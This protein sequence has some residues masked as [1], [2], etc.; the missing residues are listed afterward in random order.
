MPSANGNSTIHNNSTKSPS[1]QG[2]LPWYVQLFQGENLTYVFIGLSVLAAGILLCM[3]VYFCCAVACCVKCYIKRSQR[4]N[5]AEKDYAVLE[6]LPASAAVVLKG[7]HKKE[8]NEASVEAEVSEG[9]I[10]L[11]DT[12][13]DAPSI[14]LNLHTLPLA[15]RPVSTEQEEEPG[16]GVEPLPGVTTA[17]ERECLPVVMHQDAAAPSTPPSRQQQ[18]R[19]AS[20][21]VGQKI[22]ECTA[23][24]EPDYD[25]LTA[26]HPPSHMGRTAS[27]NPIIVPIAANGYAYLNSIHTTAE[28]YSYIHT[29]S[30]SEQEPARPHSYGECLFSNEPDYANSDII[31][32]KAGAIKYGDKEYA[33][34]DIPEDP[35]EADP[36]LLPKASGIEHDYTE[37]DLPL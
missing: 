25:S 30:A 20:M 7:Y 13:S 12:N 22:Q 1:L 29:A 10:D 17:D 14:S 6:F 3:V 2:L 19:P 34:I 26:V 35:A 21:P 37:I 33:E 27:G 16:E 36:V 18:R 15:C 9:S 31:A 23:L 11:P 5:P 28:G 4:T 8:S 32:Q 24:N